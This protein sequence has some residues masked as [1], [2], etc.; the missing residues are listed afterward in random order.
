MREALIGNPLG[1]V[2]SRLLG[3]WR[4]ALTMGVLDY[5]HEAPLGPLLDELGVPVDRCDATLSAGGSAGAY[6]LTLNGVRCTMLPTASSRV[7]YTKAENQQRVRVKVLQGEAHQAD[8]C[9]S[10]GECWI[11]DLPPNLPKLSP[12]QVRYACGADGL[13]DGPG[14]CCEERR[15]CVR[16][17]IRRQRRQ[18]QRRHVVQVTPD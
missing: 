1:W 18:C 9:I 13:V 6:D 7:Y 4:R 5:R 8:A 17:R 12:V 11:E 15:R 14:E 3:G 16:K 10:I 2:Q